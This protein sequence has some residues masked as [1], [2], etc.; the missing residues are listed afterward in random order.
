MIS[1]LIRKGCFA[2]MEK[3][4]KE[5]LPEIVELRHDLHAHPQIYFEETYAAE[6]V[7]KI[8]SALGIQC[9]A[10]VAKTGVVGWVLPEDHEARK[11]PAIGLRADMD[12][13]PMQEETG[14][15][16]T[17]IWPQRMHACG[18]DGNTAVLCGAAM[19]LAGLK[20]HLPCPVKFFF[21]PAEELGDGAKAMIS[22][23]AM[24]KEM[25]GV[26]VDR[27]FA[28]HANP[29]LK[30]GQV[31]TR[32]GPLCARA[33]EMKIMVSGQ[34]GHAAKPESAR[35]PILAAA[36]IIQNL[37]SV[38]SRNVGAQESAVVTIGQIH[39]GTKSNIIPEVVNL[40]GT[41]RT[42][43]G[44]I[45]EDVLQRVKEVVEFTA[46]AMGCV[47]A[48]EVIHS[49][50]LTR[51]DPKLTENC[52]KVAR[53][54][55]GENNVIEVKRTMGAEDFCYFSNAVPGCMLDVGVCPPGSESYPGLHNDKFDYS[56]ETLCVGVKLLCSL[57]LARQN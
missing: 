42:F 43:D 5:K 33:D 11:K 17:S 35:D 29:G 44:D 9:I 6:K 23:G 47:G 36:A 37:Q 28:L 46:K 50:P 38:V 40:S 20:R 12:A 56:D 24:T 2:E 25:G 32:S 30:I 27:M 16:Y 49:L 7:Q 15:P 21:Q 57:V 4:L 41:I 8:L 52:I 31:G 10:G 19:V 48:F 14:L 3:L 34:G 18:H 45:T 39:G 26:E 22:E 1:D 53:Q 13:L 51:N 54:V 55:F